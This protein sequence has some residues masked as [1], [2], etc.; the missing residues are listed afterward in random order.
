VVNSSQD[1]PGDRAIRG[2]SG[3][4]RDGQRLKQRDVHAIAGVGKIH[5]WIVWSDFLRDRVQFS[6]KIFDFGKHF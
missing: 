6:P 4:R 3:W 5:A 2:C 1:G